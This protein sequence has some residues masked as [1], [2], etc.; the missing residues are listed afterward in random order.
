MRFIIAASLALLSL[1]TSPSQ[2]PVPVEKEPRHHLKFENSH[3]RIFDA[4]V[5]PGDTTLYH[6]HPNDYVFVMIGPATIKAQIEG[7]EP[8]DLILKDGETRYTPAPITHRVSNVG[9]TGFRAIAIEVRAPSNAGKAIDRGSEYSLVLENERVRV[10]RLTL[11]PDQSTR[12][13][14]SGQPEVMVAITRGE[15]VTT[16]ASAVSGTVG[17]GNRAKKKFSPG[18]FV[19]SDGRG[20]RSMKNSG[21]ARFEAITV[22][23]K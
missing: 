10:E 12:T 15:V 5:P 23:W 1:G 14:S 3:V 2:A 22:E 6:H 18:D 17:Y 21:K 11:E 20:T 9:K 8:Y 19:W 4:V 16:A 7:G 13:E